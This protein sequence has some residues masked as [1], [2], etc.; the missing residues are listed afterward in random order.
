MM[1]VNR[2]ALAVHPLECNTCNTTVRTKVN[3]S[4]KILHVLGK[5]GEGFGWEFIF[6]FSFGLGFFLHQNILQR[7]YNNQNFD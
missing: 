1:V 2:A 7:K 3:M 6:C 5:R 4:V